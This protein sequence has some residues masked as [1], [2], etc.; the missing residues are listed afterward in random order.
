VTGKRQIVKKVSLG[1]AGLGTV[2]QGVLEIIANNRALIAQR[3]GIEFTVARVASRR[4]KPEVALAGA[5]F[6]TQLSDLYEDP[7]VDVVLELIGGETVAYAF[8]QA[9]VAAGKPLVTA[10]KAVI[11]AHGNTLLS[12][13]P[14][15]AVRFEAAVAGA[16]P[17]I[18][19]IQQGLVANRFEYVVGIINGTCNYILTA[20]QAQGAA[21]ADALQTAQALGYA[22]ADPTFDIEGIDAAHK[23]AILLSLAFDR[24][25][26]FDDVY[27]EGISKV[28]SA[29][30]EYADQLGY[31]IKHLGIARRTDQ[32]LEARVHPTLVPKSQLLASVNDVLNAVLVKSDAAGATLYC[33]PGAGGAATASAVMA[34]VVALASQ[35]STPRYR[36]EAA[37]SELQMVPI[38]S[39]QSA[40]Y[41]RIPAQDQPGVFASVAKALSQHGISIEAAIQKEAQGGQALVD[42]VFLTQMTRELEMT[43]ALAQVQ[44]MPEVGG[45]LSRIRL[46]TLD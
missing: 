20:M 9:V 21:F 40:Y 30:I 2:A 37:Q 44:N 16:I 3:T 7:E 36:P 25:F 12:L 35:E 43:A 29:D 24:P 41:L 28:T 4:P 34:D 32:G 8:M 19:A 46:E 1:I 14:D 5:Q 23:L 15:A 18:Q 11:A 33:G 10:N 42:I 45:P 17:I 26:N 6:S 31:K 39:V 27:V 13:R 38:E 22:E